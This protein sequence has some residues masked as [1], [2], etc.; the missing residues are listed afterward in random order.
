MAAITAEARGKWS[1]RNTHHDPVMGA[2]MLPDDDFADLMARARSG[3]PAAIRAF[4]RQFERE[5]RM[6]VRARLPRRLRTQFDSSDF[7]QA[8]WQSFFC[9]LQQHAL[10]FANTDH[11]RGFLAGVV[12]NKVRQQH[13]RLTRT[14]KYDLAREERLYI[15]R[16][17][18]EVVREVL[19]PDP[20]PSETAQ[21]GDFLEKLIA[22][23]SPREVAVI[24]LR[25]QGLTLREIADRTGL[26]E[27]TVRRIIEAAWSQ[28]EHLQ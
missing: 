20:S 11:L 25:R 16:G 9:D 7:V 19:S 1:A 12:R 26:N 21:A 4:L 10:E 8:V 23:R 2:V 18:R 15:R 24:T 28:V 3:E 5:V 6:M 22:G 14:E 17:D 13:R 27:R